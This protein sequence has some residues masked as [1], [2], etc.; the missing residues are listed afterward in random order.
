MLKSDFSNSESK[1]ETYRDHKNFSFENFKTSLDNALRR[2][3]TDY[4]NFEYIYVGVKYVPS[5]RI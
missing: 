1:L 4:K 3:L 2:C 5:L